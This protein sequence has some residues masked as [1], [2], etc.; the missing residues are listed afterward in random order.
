LAGRFYHW[1]NKIAAT[2]KDLKETNVSSKGNIQ[3][4]LFGWLPSRNIVA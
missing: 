3:I 4:L 2:A 1:G